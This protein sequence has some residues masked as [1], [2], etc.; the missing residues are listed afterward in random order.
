MTDQQYARLAAE[1]LSGGLVARWTALLRPCVRLRVA[2]GGEE[3]VAVLGGSP[4]LPGGVGWPE[5]DG[6][7][8]L[9]FVA[10]VRCDA[11]PRAGL[12][13]AFP[14]AGT[15]LFFH[16]DSRADED[17]FVSVDDPESW[18][19]AR[20]VYVPQGTPVAPVDTPPEIEAFPRVALAAD[21]EESAPD[22]G[23]PQARRALLGDD[24]HWPHPRDTPAELK[25]FLRA[26]RRLRTRIGH[27]VGGH[28]LPVQ[29][30]VEYDIAGG[31]AAAEGG[32]HAEGGRFLD[33]EAER[34][35]LLTQFSSDGSARTT[36]PD[37]GTLYWLIRPED[38]AA[39]RFDRARLTVQC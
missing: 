32:L 11:L 31:T 28:A 13:E 30:P 20:V 9:S 38:L 37:D 17:A 27:Q 14:T 3:A 6:Y 10:S 26:F 29:G 33:R 36:S 19:G 8:P 35:V 15:L 39:R 16:F 1:W 4:E 23:L 2:V 21:V 25:P 5:W 24:R 34:W 18:A 12:P 22:L 7:G